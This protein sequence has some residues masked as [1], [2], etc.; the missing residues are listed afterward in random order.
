[1]KAADDHMQLEAAVDAALT[2]VVVCW[3]GTDGSAAWIPTT[4]NWKFGGDESSSSR[5]R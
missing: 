2:A 5:G 4:R 1:M 3:R